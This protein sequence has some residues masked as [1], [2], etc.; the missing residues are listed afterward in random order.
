MEEI[1]FRELIE[2]FLNT[3]IHEIKSEYETPNVNFQFGQDGLALFKGIVDNPFGKEGSWTPNAKEEDIT[4]LLTHN[5]ESAPTIFIDDSLA[6]FQNL[7]DIVNEYIELYYQYYE[8]KSARALALQILRRIWLRM[9]IEDISNVN[10]FLNKQLEFIRN[11]TFDTHTTEKIGL[12]EEYEVSMKVDVNP[13]WDE[14]TR[15]MTFTIYGD[16]SEYEL[17]RILFDIDNHQTCYIYGVQSTKR[18]KDKTIERKLYAI[19]KNIENPNVYP[20]KVYALLYFIQQLKKKGIT[21]VKIPSMQVLSYRYH[22][23][24]SKQ[25][26]QDLEQMQKRLAEH[27]KDKIVQW[28]YNQAKQWYDR[29]HNKQDVISYLKTEELMNLI[30]RILEHDTSIQILN[31]INIQGDYLDIR[32]KQSR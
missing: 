24:L 5:E 30:Y 15:S 25:A 23:L 22:E 1:D 29:V 2:L 4:F 18:Q 9:G 17:P 20:S 8:K 6:F 14:T 19:N 27:P 16:H 31:D 21:K 3:S 7:T 10:E 32:I 28:K 12:L 13:T 11:R 26:K